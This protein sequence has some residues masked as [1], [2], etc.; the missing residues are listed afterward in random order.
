VKKLLSVIELGGYEDFT[1]LYK[2]MG[3]EVTQEI[4]TRKAISRLKRTHYDVVVAEF[5]YQHTF[6]DRLS[7]LESVIAG[8]QKQN[9][10]CIVIYEKEF[11]NHLS[12]L[13]QQFNFDAELSLPISPADMQAA[14]ETVAALETSTLA[15]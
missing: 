12:T 4:T 5:N 2:S 10:K 7:N 1:E 11:E 3:Y 6:R 15:D 13:R 14:L 9:A 8:I